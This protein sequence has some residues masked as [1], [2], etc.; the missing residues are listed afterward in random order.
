[1]MSLIAAVFWAMGSVLMKRAVSEMSKAVV[2]W[3]NAVFFLTIWLVF[4]VINGG[5]RGDVWALL[6]AM[7]PGLGFV[8]AM[9][10][11]SK[12]DISLINSV[13]AIHPVVTAILAVSLLGEMLR[14]GQWWLIMLVVVGVIVMGWPGKQK[15]IRSGG[16]WWGLGFGALSGLINFVSKWGIGLVGTMSYSLMV[17]SWQ[18]LFGIVWLVM[19]KK[20]TEVKQ[21]LSKSKRWS[22]AGIGLYNLGSVACFLAIGLG[23]VSVV[24]PVVNLFV[25]LSLGLAAWWLK[26]KMNRQQ[27]IGAGVVIVSVTWLSLIS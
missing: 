26:E 15:T 23:K 12:V 19:S 27:L 18:M 24:M 6:L 4:W 20:V 1:M 8:Y 5:F 22:V 3:A 9:W 2:Y 16:W 7:A 25:P 13:G 10:A 14:I 11:Y 17:S 21:L